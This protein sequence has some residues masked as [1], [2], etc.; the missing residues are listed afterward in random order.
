MNYPR[1]V[2][3]PSQQSFWLYLC[4]T[5]IS[6]VR[7]SSQSIRG[8]TRCARDKDRFAHDGGQGVN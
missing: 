8:T 4:P 5:P 6:A 3:A 7:G 2:L 1:S